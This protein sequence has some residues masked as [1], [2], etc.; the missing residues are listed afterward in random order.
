MLKTYLLVSILLFSVSVFS[1]PTTYVNVIEDFVETPFFDE[2]FDEPNDEL[3]DNFSADNSANPYHIL[4]TP[5]F[6]FENFDPD[7]LEKQKDIEP[8]EITDNNCDEKIRQTNSIAPADEPYYNLED[9]DDLSIYEKFLAD[10]QGI[11]V[12]RAIA[13]SAETF[14]PRQCDKKYTVNTIHNNLN[15][16]HDEENVRHI[17]ANYYAY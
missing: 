11:E 14:P 17:N 1:K 12:H 9:L 4:N 10:N 13:F 16:I 3:N 6:A 15:R 2:S 7:I 5:E 8:E